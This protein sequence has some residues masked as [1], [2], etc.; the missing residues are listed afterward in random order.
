MHDVDAV[1][2]NMTVLRRD[3]GGK[4]TKQSLYFSVWIFYFLEHK[5]HREIIIAH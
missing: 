3:I 4:K 2:G 1:I 5:N